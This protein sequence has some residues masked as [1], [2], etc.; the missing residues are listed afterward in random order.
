MACRVVVLFDD[1]HGLLHTLLSAVNGQLAVVQ[2]RTN[3]QRFFE[4]AYV[5]IE[6]AKE[7]FD[8]PGDVYGASHPR[9]GLAR[10]LVGELVR[11]TA[12]GRLSY[13]WRTSRFCEPLDRFAVTHRLVDPPAKADRNLNDS[14]TQPLPAKIYW[15]PT[16][17]PTAVQGTVTRAAH[18]F[19]LMPERAL[20]QGSRKPDSRLPASNTRKKIRPS[21]VASLQ[22]NPARF[23]R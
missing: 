21:E 6:G 12:R 19:H 3:A 2:V 14:T 4:K 18:R 9:R 11:R 7:R 5:F 17:L 16:V 20:R 10:R 23:S 22:G 15:Q 1:A 13:G 8:F